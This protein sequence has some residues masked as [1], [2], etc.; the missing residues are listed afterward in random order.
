MLTRAAALFRERGYGPTSMQALSA[1]MDMG[2]QSIYNAFGSKEQV[3][4]RALEQYCDDTEQALQQLSAPGASRGAIEAW[5][6]MVLE[7]ASSGT[8][9]CLVSQTCVA[10]G[11]DDTPA[12]RKASGH[13]RKIEG[14]FQRAVENA[15]QKGEASC[16]DPQLA[17]RYLNMSMQGLGVMAR[18]GTPGEVLKQMVT[19]AMGV[20]D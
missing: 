2:E 1:A 17:A 4:Q 12:A 5:F 8:P 14:Y 13:M 3:F 20:L 7:V 18:S 16:E 6:D 15:V 19:M 9:T 11:T 10:H